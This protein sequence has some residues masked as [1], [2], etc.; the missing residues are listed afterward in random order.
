MEDGRR[1][2]DLIF[3]S[4]IPLLR[5]FN[6]SAPSR[7]VREFPLTTFRICSEKSSL[8]NLILYPEFLFSIAN[9]IITLILIFL[10]QIKRKMHKTM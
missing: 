1:I 6:S 3:L 4:T 10:I 7:Y 8:S 5:E 9:K 2:S